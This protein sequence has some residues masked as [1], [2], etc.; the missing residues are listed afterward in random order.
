[1]TQPQP[2]HKKLYELIEGN[3]VSAF[4]EDSAFSNMKKN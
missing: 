4:L 1:M 3:K 2:Q